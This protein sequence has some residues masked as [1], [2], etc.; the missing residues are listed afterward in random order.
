[1]VDFYRLN[2]IIHID[3]DTLTATV[4]AGIIWEKLDHELKKQGMT[5]WLYPT[6]YPASTAGGWLAQGGAGIGSYEAGWFR[7][8]VINARVVLPDGTVREF[9]GDELDLIADAEGITGLI[10]EITIRIQPMEDLEVVATGCPDPHELQR[11]LQSLID[12]KLPIWSLVFINPRMAE[13]KNR[14]PLM[15]HLG[16]PAG[17]ARQSGGAN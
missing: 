11:F 3:P 14:A 2:N 7:E 4:Q 1:M 5:L 9:S 17:Y 6:S 15:E 13:L 16:H 8:N 10:S 12:N